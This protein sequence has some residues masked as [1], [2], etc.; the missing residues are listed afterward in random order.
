L[1]SGFTAG[2]AFLLG[3]WA[4]GF[5]QA[6]TAEAAVATWA[7]VGIYEVSVVFRRERHVVQ[8]LRFELRH[9]LRI[10]AWLVRLSRG[11][12]DLLDGVS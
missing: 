7:V 6:W 2:G 3:R 5:A 11:C 10:P 9:E 4:P 12:A 1:G 8:R